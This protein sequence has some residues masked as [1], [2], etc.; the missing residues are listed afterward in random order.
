M[1]LS[2]TQ[3]LDARVI[4]YRLRLRPISWGC[5]ILIAVLS[6]LPAEEMVR[7]NLGGHVEHVTAY[8]GTTFLLC[9][10]YPGCKWDDGLCMYP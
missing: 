9:F 2:R 4:A 1:P 7:T 8:A 10:S 5:I 6:L 3:M